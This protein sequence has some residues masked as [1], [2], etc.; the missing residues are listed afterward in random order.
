MPPRDP[1]AI[2]LD[3]PLLNADL[4]ADLRLIGSLGLLNFL[5]EVRPTYIIGSRAGALTVTAS[6]IIY[7]AS[8]IFDGRASNPAA[9]SVVVD[10]GALAAGDYDVI[11]LLTLTNS[12]MAQEFIQLE[13]RDA[14]NAVSLTRWP[15]A[16]RDGV[17]SASLTM[18][19]TMT[20]ALNERFR[21]T[22]GT[23]ITG[24]VGGTIMAKLRP[25]P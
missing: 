1:S 8:E 25:T 9:N 23:A 13:H 18:T 14:A 17:L 6:P 16:G 2:Q 19:F 7:L 5:P 10:T 21:I 3:F 11:F 20:L 24:R 15:M 22:N 12:V 4:L